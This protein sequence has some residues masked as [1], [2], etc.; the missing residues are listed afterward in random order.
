MLNQNIQLS[1]IQLCRAIV[2]DYDFILFNISSLHLW[3]LLKR[4]ML[5]ELAGLINSF[6]Y[7]TIFTYV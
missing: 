1:I 4:L 5:T 3:I 6:P 2:S 7:G